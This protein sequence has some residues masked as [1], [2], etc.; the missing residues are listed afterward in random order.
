MAFLPILEAWPR[1]RVLERLHAA[2]ADDVRRCLHTEHLRMEDMLRLFSPA[3]TDLLEDMARR[4]HGEHLRH[5]G[6]TVTFFTPLYMSDHCTNQ[7]R[8]CGFNARN[9]Q[10]RHHL[11]VEEVAREAE[12]IAQ[13]GLSHVLLLTGDA[14]H[15]SS[16]TYIAGAAGAV[17]SCMA[18]VC[19]E[20]Y[21]MT[22]EEYAL[23][24]AHGVDGMTI[25]QETYN[26]ELYGRLHPAGPKRDFVFRLEAPGRAAAAGMRSIGIGAL[27]GLDDWRCD[28]FY[29]ALHAHWLQSAWPAVECSVSVPRL[30]PSSSHFTDIHPVTDR[31]IVQYISALRCFMPRLG[32]TLST[33]ESAKLRDNLL[34]L[35]VSR[36][37]AGVS[38]A[39]GT[40]ASGHSGDGQFQIADTRSV[41]ELS[42][43]L[44]RMGYQAVLKDWEEPG[45]PLPRIPQEDRDVQRA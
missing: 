6:R 36:M 28:A 33:R 18:S 24:F 32:I 4:A 5:F 2:S 1:E 40:R 27:L 15:L 22:R 45:P 21:A 13:S 42:D 8:Y 12:A 11:S 23:L 25:F 39:V 14:R 29:T 10:R 3:A 20:V 41:R 44:A 31:D 7:C 9:R 43:D 38:T 30:R 17:R 34:P 19:V 35:G 26:R 37:S 16:P